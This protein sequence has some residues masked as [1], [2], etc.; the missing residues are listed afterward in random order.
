MFTKSTYEKAKMLDIYNDLNYFLSA[1]V[2]IWI[3]N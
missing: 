2:R 3:T 1:R